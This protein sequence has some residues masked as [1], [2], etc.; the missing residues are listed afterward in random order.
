MD[1]LLNPDFGLMVWT[2]VTFLLVAFV[3]GRFAWKPIL[4]SL[5]EREE[6]LRSVAR[7]AEE[8]RRGAESLKADY[9]RQLADMQARGQ[10]MLQAAQKDAQRLRDEMLKAAQ[11]ESARL[12]EKTRK[13]LAEE[14]QRLVQDLRSD[15]V[16]L[17]V[18]MA[19]KLLRSSLDK[20]VQ[21]K[22]V[23]DALAELEKTSKS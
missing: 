20:K 6:G 8:A 13:D 12:A 19:E 15:V 2:V 16:G 22:F 23:E 14:Q 4:R 11:D 17:S 21:D 5:D 10:E 3:L 7:A 1:K 9:D 18:K